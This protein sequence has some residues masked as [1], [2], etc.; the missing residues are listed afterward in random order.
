MKRMASWA[1]IEAPLDSLGTSRR[2]ERAPAALREAGLLEG[3]AQTAVLGR[4]RV[5]ACLGGTQR[6]E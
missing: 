3:W 2:E 6:P 4:R 5:S 1:A